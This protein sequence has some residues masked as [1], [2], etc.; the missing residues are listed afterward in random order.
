MCVTDMLRLCDNHSDAYSIITSM[1]TQFRER[2]YKLAEHQ[3]YLLAVREKV[4]NKVKAFPSGALLV[5]GITRG[6][7]L[8][9]I[10]NCLE[11]PTAVVLFCFS[12][13]IFSR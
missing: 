11:G 8:N 7:L 3:H 6:C 4:Q 5:E 12:S 9:G 10:T 1:M 13:L 2:I